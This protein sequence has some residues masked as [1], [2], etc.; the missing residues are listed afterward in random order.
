MPNMPAHRRSTGL[1]PLKPLTTPTSTTRLRCYAREGRHWHAS[2]DAN[3]P[4][5]LLLVEPST[6]AWRWEPGFRS[7]RGPWC[8]EA[9]QAPWRVLGWLPA[10]GSL[11]LGEPDE[12]DPAIARADF[13]TSPERP[14]P[15][16]DARAA[17]HSGPTYSGATGR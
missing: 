11:P 8:S 16:H 3:V 14:T 2:P 5:L 10:D 15:A 13:C 17:L 6:R 9:A 12:I 4:L 7:T 1:F